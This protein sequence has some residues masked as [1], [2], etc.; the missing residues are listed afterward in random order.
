MNDA[1]MQDVL[2]HVR[3]R[4]YGKYRGTVTTVDAATMRLQATVPS[5]L[6]NVPTGWALPCVP[7]AGPKV[8]F[9][10]LPD[11]GAN[12]WIEFEGGDPS[13]PIW[14]GCFW[15][16][17]DIPA[18]A[19]SGVNSIVTTS[20]TLTFDNNAGTITL[21]DST[22]DSLTIQAS[23]ATLKAGTG[24]IDLGSGVSINGGALQVT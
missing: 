5:V 16:S 23:K 9:V 11:V 19:A 2:T 12:V 1:G 10:M 17:G 14:T 13:Y 24:T 22:G 21:Q 15:G 8:G 4:F 20:G 18:I 3:Q 6:P 7:Y